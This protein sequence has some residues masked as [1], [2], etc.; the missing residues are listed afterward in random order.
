MRSIG[1]IIR[2][3]QLMNDCLDPEEMRGRVEYF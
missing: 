3:L 2:F 1:D